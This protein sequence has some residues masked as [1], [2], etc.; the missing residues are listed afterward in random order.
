M[1]QDPVS[2]DTP[3]GEDEDCYLGDV[4]E[5]P[6][7]SSPSELA[8]DDMLKEELVETLN[9]NPELLLEKAHQLVAVPELLVL[10]ISTILIFLLVGMVFVKK[11]RLKYFYI[12][13][14][15]TI[16]SG[17]ILLGIYLLPNLVHKFINI[18]N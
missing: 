14:M 3:V 5:D 13:L 4:I 7:I 15:S 17:S 16:L 2:L 11:S 10:F 18:I 12:W 1:I 6:N 8:E 9:N